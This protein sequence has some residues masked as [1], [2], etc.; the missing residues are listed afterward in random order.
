MRHFGAI[1]LVLVLSSRAPA[2][3]FS[4][5]DACVDGRCPLQA[6]PSAPSA[7]DLRVDARPIARIVN[8]RGAV[9]AAGT[10][11]LVDVDAD[12][13]LVITCAHLFREGTGA[14]SVTFPDQATLAAKV[15]KIDADADLAAL[16]IPTT[17]IEPVTVATTYPRRGDSLVSCGYGGDGRLWCN[18]GQALGY[19]ATANGQNLETL[20]LSGAARFGDS[21]GPVLDR[22]HQ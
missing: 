2:Q 1:L 22:D 10:G 19:V 7:A 12:G 9:R 4:G 18:R 6:A 15:E 8:Q 17:T 13:G 20:E 11:T 21:G 3:Q 14:V 5:D 16:S